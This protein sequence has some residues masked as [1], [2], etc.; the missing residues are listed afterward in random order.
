MGKIGAEDAQLIKWSWESMQA[1][2]FSSMILSD[3]E[4][5]VRDYHDML[6][7]KIPVSALTDEPAKGQVETIN[8]TLLAA[9]RN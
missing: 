9:Q 5:G 7:R 1:S 2:G 4:A 8:Q 3:L 6:R